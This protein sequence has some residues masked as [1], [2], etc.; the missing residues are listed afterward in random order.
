MTSGEKSFTKTVRMRRATFSQV[1]QWI[2][3]A[4]SSVKESTITNGCRKAGLLRDEEDSASSRA[5]LPRE[6]SDIDSANERETE[7]NEEILRLFNSDTE[8][9]NFNGFSAQEDDGD[10]DQ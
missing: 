1:C 9:V 2:L 4:W 10:S 8:E 3:T 7:C 6:E 5:D